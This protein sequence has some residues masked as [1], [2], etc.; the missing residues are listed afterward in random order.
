MSSTRGDPPPVILRDATPADVYLFYSWANDPAACAASFETATIEHAEHVAWFSAQLERDDRHLL[1]A[2]QEARPVAV[3]R[4]DRSPA[5]DSTCVISVNV[6]PEARGRG[7][8][9]QVLEAAASAATRL[10]F[11]RIHALI[12]PENV[13]SARAFSSA[14]FVELEPVRSGD[15]PARLFC[16][17]LETP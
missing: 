6:A 14:G 11:A 9:R 17:D 8:G 2:E 4:L 12:K 10:G 13:A 7:L 3:V 16:R 5:L 15:R 1:L